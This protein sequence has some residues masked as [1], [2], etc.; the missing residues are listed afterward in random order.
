MRKTILVVCLVCSLVIFAGC[1]KKEENKNEAGSQTKQTEGKFMGTFRDLMKKGEAVKCEYKVTTEGFEQKNTL[2]VSGEKMRMDGA[3]KMS[4]QKDIIN[5]MINIDDYTYFW[6]EDGTNKGTKM[7]IES[8][9]NSEELADVQDQNMQID[10][11]T[12]MDMDCDKWNEDKSLFTL[13]SSIEFS[14]LSEM[15]KSFGNGNLCASCDYL[16]GKDK[17]EC[18]TNMCK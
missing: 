16:S 10:L 14:D 9:D 5:H 4:G 18:Q 15:M 1:G 2:Y 13:P 6:N 17:T 3:T 11:D 8:K 7:K 12:A